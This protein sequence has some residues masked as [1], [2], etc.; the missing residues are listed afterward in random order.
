MCA[1]HYRARCQ[2]RICRGLLFPDLSSANLRRLNAI[3]KPSSPLVQPQRQDYLLPHLEA[4]GAVVAGA[5]EVRD[6]VDSTPF[7]TSR[8]FHVTCVVSEGTAVHRS[9]AIH[10]GVN[11]ED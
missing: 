6:G 9:V 1:N 2:D 10:Q 11:D 7:N 8:L 5:P 3:Y 4:L